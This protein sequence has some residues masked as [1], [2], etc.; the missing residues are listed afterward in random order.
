MTVNGLI[1]VCPESKTVAPAPLPP[2]AVIG[3]W[4]RL[5]SV[6]IGTEEDWEGEFSPSQL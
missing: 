1:V 3:F 6:T 5:P 4:H 2:A